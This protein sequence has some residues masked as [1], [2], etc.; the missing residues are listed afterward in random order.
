[1][2]FSYE[3]AAWTLHSSG[4]VVVE[5]LPFALADSALADEAA[6]GVIEIATTAGCSSQQR[7]CSHE[8]VEHPAFQF[9]R[10]DWQDSSQSFPVRGFL[11]RQPH[12]SRGAKTPQ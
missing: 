8:N 7:E 10:E 9:D 5:N 1:M 4:R 3:L 2:L 11:D 12:Q 6:K